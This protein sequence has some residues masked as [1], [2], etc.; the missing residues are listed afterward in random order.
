M[1]KFFLVFSIF[2][3][4]AL[5]SAGIHQRIKDSQIEDTKVNGLAVIYGPTLNNT[6]NT[7]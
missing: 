5:L 1:R 7:V 3:L 4:L 6:H 2:V